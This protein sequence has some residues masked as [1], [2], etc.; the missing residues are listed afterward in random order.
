MMHK[1]YKFCKK[2]FAENKKLKKQTWEL[3]MN[4]FIIKE[5]SIFYT[6]SNQNYYWF[7]IN[8]Q[9]DY[10]KLLNFKSND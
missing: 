1:F 4:D 2:K 5:K 9:K 7:N 3:L 8:T 6:L 10:L